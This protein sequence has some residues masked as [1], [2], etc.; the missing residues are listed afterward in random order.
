MAA[1][2][3]IV[4]IIAGLILC[5]FIGVP[6]RALLD[7]PVPSVLAL[8][9]VIAP[10][11]E[12]LLLQ[13]LPVAIARGLKAG[14]KVQILASLIPFTLLHLPEGVCVGICAGLVGGFY[15]AF[16][17]AHWIEKS[18]WTALWTTTVAHIIRN[19]LPALLITLV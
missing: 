13:A 4:S 1:E 10:V 14:F 16:N 19:S 2:G 9:L 11:V 6:R 7:L 12:T 5:I 15:L 17:Y 3:L 18:L 8:T